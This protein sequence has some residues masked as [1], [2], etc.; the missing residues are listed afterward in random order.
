MASYCKAQLIGLYP[1]QQPV[2]LAPPTPAPG[3]SRT[4]E[5]CL[6]EDVYVCWHGGPITYGVDEATVYVGSEHVG[7]GL[8]GVLPQRA[9]VSQQGLLVDG[10]Q[11]GPLDLVQR[12]D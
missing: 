12:V 9:A 3:H 2:H 1:L 10:A 8:D 7:H 5:A 4:T 11:L 6:E